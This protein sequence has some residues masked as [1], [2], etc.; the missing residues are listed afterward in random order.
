MRETANIDGKKVLVRDDIYTW[1]NLISFSRVLV[2]FPI[3]YLHMHNDYQVNSFIWGLILYGAFSDYLDGL[4]ARWRNEIS[5][6]GKSLDPIADKLAAFFL[7]IYTVWLGWI[8]LWYFVL[9]VMRDTLIM[10]GSAH[11]KKERGKVAMSIMSGKVTVN[12]M[13]FYWISVFFFPGAE[14]V[15]IFFMVSSAVMMIVS[16]VEYKQRYHKIINGADFN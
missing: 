16:F 10:A 2:V 15:H 8:P 13:A 7:F 11:I 4:V 1:S 6:L 14:N 3:I 9:G 12:F 5:E